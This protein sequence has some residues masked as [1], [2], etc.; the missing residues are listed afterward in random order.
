PGDF[1]LIRYNVAGRRLWH[2]RLVP[3]LASAPPWGVGILTPDGGAYVEIVIGGADSAECLV[4]DRGAAGGGAAALGGDATYRFNA[5]PLGPVVAQGAQDT[6]AMLG[7]GVQP[8]VVPNT[9]GRAIVP[10]A[11]DAAGGAA[12]A[13]G[14]A[15]AAGGVAGLAAALAGGG[16]GAAAAPGG[17]ALVAAP[18]ALV[19]PPAGGAPVGAAPQPGAPAAAAPAAPPVAAHVA[20]AA[21]AP[22][23]APFMGA[24][25]EA[26]GGDLRI[27]AVQTDIRGQRHRPFSEAARLLVEPGVGNHEMMCRL[28][29]IG[30]CYDQLHGSNLASMELVARSI[31]TENERY[32]HR[33][34]SSE[35]ADLNHNLMI[36]MTRGRGHV[37]ACPALRD[38]VS[39]QLQKEAS[40]AKERRK[41]REE[42]ALAGG[43]AAG[44]GAGGGGRG[45][46]KKKGGKGGGRGDAAA[47]GAGRQRD[48]FPMP[49]VGGGSEYGKPTLSRR[50]LLNESQRT[51]IQNM[52]TALHRLGRQHEQ[53]AEARECEDGAL[54]ELLQGVAIYGDGAC[55]PS[56]PYRREQ[57]SWP[58][59][60]TPPVEL[61][62]ILGPSEAARLRDWRSQ[63]LRPP[64]EA[65]E[66]MATACPRG[67]YCDQGL[68]GDPRTYAEFL[69]KLYGKGM[70]HFSAA[71]D[72]KGTVGA[73]FVPKK[74]GAQRVIFD[75]RI[76]NCFLKAPPKTRLPTAAA[77]SA[78]EAPAS[79][80][81][82]AT[83]DLECAFYHMK[84]PSGMEE[85]FS[86]PAIDSTFLLEAGLDDLPFGPDVAAACLLRSGVDPS[87]IV[88][89]GQ[90]GIALGPSRLVAA[91]AYVDNVVTIGTSAE[92]ANSLMHSLVRRFE[93]AGHVVHEIVEASADAQ[94]LGLQLH[95]GKALTVKAKNVWRLRAALGSLLR[96][97]WVTGY[98]LRAVLG[99]ITWMSMLRREALTT[100]HAC[101]A[102]V[103]V[104]EGRPGRLWDSA[105][106]ELIAVRNLL[107]ILQADL[108]AGWYNTIACSDTAPGGLGVARQRLEATVVASC[109]RFSERWRFKVARAQAARERS[110]ACGSASEKMA[111]TKNGYR[112]ADADPDAAETPLKHVEPFPNYIVAP[113]AD[114][115]LDSGRALAE[116]PEEVSEGPEG[117]AVR[118]EEVPADITDSPAWRPSAAVQVSGGANI[119]FLEG[120]G[121]S[122]PNGTH[123][124]QSAAG[125]MA[126]SAGGACCAGPR[127]ALLLAVAVVATVGPVGADAARKSRVPSA[128]AA[129]AQRQKLA[130]QAR[131]SRPLLAGLTLLETLAIRA[132]TER[133][134]LQ[135][136]NNFAQWC[137]Q[138]RQDWRTYE[139][140]DLVLSSY[141]SDHYL[142]GTACNIGSQTLAAIARVTPS[143]FK[144]TVSVLPRASRA[145]AAWKR[146]APGKTRLPLPRPA[147]YAIA[148]WLISHG[149]LGV[150]CWV[151][152]AVAAYL[153]PAEAQG[154]TRESL[155]PPAPAA[156]AGY[157]CWALLMHPLERGVAG[158]TGHYDDSV[159]I[160]QAPLWPVLAAMRLA[161][162]P[163]ASLWS[164]SLDELTAQFSSACQALK[165]SSLHEV[166]RRGRWAVASSMR[167]YGKEGS[168]LDEM[169]RVNA[170]VFAFG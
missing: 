8:A 30:L 140:L 3:C 90:V 77:W 5:T 29:E 14:G 147:V 13:A 151:V 159:L 123:R 163:G 96:R 137:Q 71:V 110:L 156:G 61:S 10:V 34:E 105:A 51:A 95:A 113:L 101:Y 24:A 126:G 97:K 42:R 86:L 79:G 161:T 114:P 6:A 2:E 85:Y 4:C 108:T 117:F 142:L 20:P 139:E 40:I 25:A 39:A 54:S 46:K 70:V 83:A 16:I 65:E 41:A 82:V 80:V 158:K 89:D 127:V 48:L 124:T 131:S 55:N 120:E 100:L 150:A 19:G 64:R 148:G 119:L 169:A 144:Q 92:V 15:G 22:A 112:A 168:L 121:G 141:F 88:V 72:A 52:N 170:D 31:Q 76:A 7:L 167:R 47:A 162:P 32:R 38:H 45:K 1:I 44:S 122:P 132:N 23:G 37:C 153:R 146:R 98:A 35:D 165:L 103:E 149:Q 116:A 157:S 115:I 78:V 67:A 17:G 21:A 136:L 50:P 104:F 99:H 75:T 74:S 133:S 160:D 135:M 33:F 125:G 118:F 128:G 58:S 18:A 11:A 59:S 94:F 164:F 87:S 145:S 68:V 53:Y 155:V 109:A 166:Q 63:M 27:M 60:S 154:L 91:G 102:F 12:A 36:G 26:P 111:A 28:L 57:I 56:V 107:P 66:L 62:T 73:F 130:Q 81:F 69:G 49:L 9:V 43:G 93:D 84:L 134:Y 106:R 143:L 138:H 129:V 152:L